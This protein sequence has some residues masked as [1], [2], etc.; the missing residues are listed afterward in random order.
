M[1]NDPAAT[2]ASGKQVNATN[3]AMTNGFL[4]SR[5]ASR[6]AGNEHMITVDRL[7]GDEHPE[8]RR[9]DAHDVDAVEHE[10]DVHHGV[11]G[12]DEDVGEEEPTQ[13]RRERPP[14]SGDA[15]RRLGGLADVEAHAPDD[16][17]RARR[18]GR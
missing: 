12:A 10:E 4:P 13:R 2:T 14:D 17:E 9:R 15:G 1:V 5:S 7:H 16:E 3:V 18:R 6:A 11:A 8:R